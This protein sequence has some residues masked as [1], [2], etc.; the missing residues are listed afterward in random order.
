MQ[1]RGQTKTASV[2]ADFT[3]STPRPLP[4]ILLADVSGSMSEDGKI[5]GLNYAIGEMINSFALEAPD[6]A[7]IQVA[8]I[9]FGGTGA[10]VHIPLTPAASTTW[11]PVKAGGMTPMGAAI[12]IATQLIEDRQMIPSRSYRPAIVIV[13]DGQPNDDWKSPL[14]ALHGSARGAKADRF[15]LGIGPDPGL[16]TLNAF[17]ADASKRVLR[18][19][20]AAQMKRFFRWVTMTVTA[21][22]KSATPDQSTEPTPP[23]LNADLF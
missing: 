3:I 14:R 8:V 10:K 21:R 18:A 23:D 7:E 11:I 16:A 5:D 19:E 13:S 17:L 4:V 20:D 1:M 6:R 22:S 2:L 15:A 9:T 12:E